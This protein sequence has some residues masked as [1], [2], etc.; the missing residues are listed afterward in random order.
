MVYFGRNVTVHFGRKLTGVVN[1]PVLLDRDLTEAE[2]ANTSTE[3]TVYSF[4]VPGGTLGATGALLLKFAGNWLAS[5]GTPSL[6]VRARCAGTVLGVSNFAGGA[7]A[8]D[9]DRAGCTGE[10][11]LCAT[12]APTSQRSHLTVWTGGR[13]TSEVGSP[14]TTSAAGAVHVSEHNGL[15][16]DPTLAQSLAVTVQWSVAHPTNSY[17]FESALLLKL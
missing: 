3:T 13:L 10:L 5:S 16:L 4:V 12:G 11:L 9:P 7:L 15:A 6:T 1:S 2:V 17:R 14:P 8:N